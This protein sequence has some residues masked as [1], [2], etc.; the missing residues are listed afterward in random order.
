V[1]VQTA[2]PAAPAR[3]LAGGDVPLTHV[4]LSTLQP[5]RAV[6]HLRDLLVEAEVLP[7]VDRF[8]FLF[9][10]WLPGWLAS[11]EDPQHRRLLERFA[12][13]HV[14]R[15]LRTI[16]TRQP[17]NSGRE[18]LAR[19]VLRTSAQF[20]THLAE[21]DRHLGDCGQ[22]DVDR[23]FATDLRR[24]EH[25]RTFLRWCIAQR[26]L[27][28]LRIPS[29]VKKTGSRLSQPQRLTFIR[30]VLT[31]PSIPAAD[32]V[33]A[34]LI[35]L[36][37]QPLVKVARLTIDDVLRE[38]DQVLLRLGDPPIPVPHPFSDVLLDYVAHRPNMSSA[39]NP[40]SRF[41]FPGRRAGQPMH[42]TSLRLR[43]RNL[44][45]PSLD[46]RTATIRQLLLEA[47]AAVVAGMLGYHAGTAETL[48]IEGGSTWTRYAAGSHSRRRQQGPR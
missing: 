6:I 3:A 16:S 21:H 42:T 4:G 31:D 48:A 27:P 19:H 44:G 43:L 35:L 25:S 13:W 11:I 47:P 45:L 2:H 34:L 28:H 20:L 26:E 17:I 10:Q 38:Q 15:K 29:V 9:E 33:L 39:T 46:A 30:H 12:T 5:W 18:N 7:P 1:A 8:L 40:N 22:R 14:L 32:R 41:L 23:W 24:A 37:A 36:Y